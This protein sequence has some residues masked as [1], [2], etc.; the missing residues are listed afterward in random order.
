MDIINL[1]TSIMYIQVLEVWIL[2]PSW[3]PLYII[4]Y[5]GVGSVDIIS[6]DIPESA[7]SGE[8]IVLDCKYEYR[9]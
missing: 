8:D 9:L 4:E 1:D 5:S 2:Y 3:I 6:L 7:E